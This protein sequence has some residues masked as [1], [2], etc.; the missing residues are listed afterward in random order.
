MRPDVEMLRSSYRTIHRADLDDSIPALLDAIEAAEAETA[1]LR[2]ALEE[3]AHAPTYDGSLCSD[4]DDCPNCFARAALAAGAGR[5]LAAEVA[6]MRPVVE[7]ALEYRE[8][9]TLWATGHG[10]QN[11]MDSKRRALFDH[12]DA[13]DAQRKGTQQKEK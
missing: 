3:I 13:L 6:A 12:I 9:A 8:A 1:A 2:F 7:A 11:N 5:K 10:S 4:P